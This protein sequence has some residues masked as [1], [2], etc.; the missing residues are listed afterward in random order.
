ML[1]YPGDAIGDANIKDKIVISKGRG[2]ARTYMTSVKEC[3]MLIFERKCF[4]D[5]LFKDMMDSL[6]EKIIAMRSSEFFESLSPYAMV[7]LCSN[8]ELHEYCYG[9]VI[10]RQETEPT[11]CF[12][13]ISGECKLVLETVLYKPMQSEKKK[14]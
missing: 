14:G 1:I 5:V 2:E 8:V 9:D 12:I 11:E 4:T 6:Y 13:I 7:I 3:D 10:L